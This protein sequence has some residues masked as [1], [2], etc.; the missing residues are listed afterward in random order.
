MGEVVPFPTK[1]VEEPEEEIATITVYSSGRVVGWLSSDVETHA[2]AEW[3]RA[4]LTDGVFCVA[5]TM[6]HIYNV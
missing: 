3:T 2:E 4:R 6:E 5:T 1:T